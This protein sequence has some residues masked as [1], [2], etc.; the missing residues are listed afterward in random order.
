[1][2]L[3]A[4][5]EN[6][7]TLKVSAGNPV[8]EEEKISLEVLPQN[9]FSAVALRHPSMDEKLS[10][11][12]PQVSTLNSGEKPDNMHWKTSEGESLWFEADEGDWQRGGRITP[13]ED[14][15]DMEYWWENEKEGIA[16]TPPE[17][18][19]DIK[20]S[21]F[22]DLDHNRTWILTTNG[23]RQANERN[24]LRNT[25]AFAVVSK[26]EDKILCMVWNN[27][28]KVVTPKNGK[29]GL[30]LQPVEFPID[31]RYH[32]RGKLYLIENDLEILKDRIMKEIL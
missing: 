28:K 6:E 26:Q 12:F 2:F 15:L 11:I 18:L 1:M 9:G 17:F 13:N 10:L 31:K 3:V 32:V 21:E 5:D 7:Q 19:I 23:W 27:P 8:E 29:T 30:A 24:D 4:S 16:H 20:N 25:G 14:N 22:E